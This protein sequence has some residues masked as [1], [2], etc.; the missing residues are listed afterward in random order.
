MSDLN[1]PNNMMLL[2]Y[3]HIQLWSTLSPCFK[4]I[5][6]LDIRGQIQ[7]RIDGLVQDCSTSIA[8]AIATAVLH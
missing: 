8:N 1:M 7:Y 5:S 6:H 4:Y 2:M 3:I